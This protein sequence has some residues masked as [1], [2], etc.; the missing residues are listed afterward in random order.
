LI[1]FWGGPDLDFSNRNEANECPKNLDFSN[2][3]EANECP[4]NDHL[5]I[6]IA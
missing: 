1:R 3:N 5:L 2:R 4:K 6:T